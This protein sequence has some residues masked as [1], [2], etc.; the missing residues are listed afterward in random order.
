MSTENHHDKEMIK[1]FN[2]VS[3]DR[4]ESYEI[5]IAEL[6]VGAYSFYTWPASK[7]LAQ[8]LFYMRK[9]LPGKNILEIGAGTS[10]PGLLAAKLG[11]HVT[12]SDS[13][14]LPKSLQHIDRI[15]NL[16]KLKPGTD[17]LVTGLT[18]GESVA[19]YFVF[20]DSNIL[21]FCRNVGH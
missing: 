18:W 16:N 17:I 9:C 1:K 12:L 3:K 7:I 5:L 15:C 14:L 4:K 20:E 6:L 11:A 19:C 13:A 21:F 10:L 8:F 2:F